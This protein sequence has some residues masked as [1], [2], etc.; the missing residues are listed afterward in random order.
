VLYQKRARLS[1]EDRAL[2]ALAMIESKGAPKMIEDLL[3]APTA[4]QAYIEQW[5]G[6]IARE[7]A[8]HLLAWTMHNARAPRVISS[9]R[10]SSRAGATATGARHRGMHGRCSRSPSYLRAVESGPEGFLR[11]D[12]VGNGGHAIPLEPRQT[13]GERSVPIQAGEHARASH[14]EESKARRCSR[15]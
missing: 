9:R 10:S 8:L 7:N 6:S 12:R 1:G 4:D 13:G 2:L 14:A 3:R 11:H 5:F 15:R